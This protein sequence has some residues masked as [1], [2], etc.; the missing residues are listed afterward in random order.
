MKINGGSETR[1]VRAAGPKRGRGAAGGAGFAERLA[2]PTT[3]APS[4]IAGP[5]SVATLLAVQAAGDAL[6]GRRQAYDRAEGLLKR[7]ESLH[8]A[9]LEGRIDDAALQRLA[10]E[11]D[12]QAE[13]CNDPALQELVGEIEL[14]AAVELAK[15]GLI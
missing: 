9:L 10:A 5:G 3:A 15:R 12:G 7:L 4:E 1:S 11:I 2:P 6:E 13:N 8:L 14:R